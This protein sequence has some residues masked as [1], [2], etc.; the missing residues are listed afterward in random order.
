[1][2][3]SRFRIFKALIE[4]YTSKK[5]H[6]LL[7]LQKFFCDLKILSWAFLVILCSVYSAQSECKVVEPADWK[8]IYS[9]T[10]PRSD[11]RPPETT[12]ESI[13]D[14]HFHSK[15]VLQMGS[16]NYESLPSFVGGAFVSTL[17]P[18]FPYE[19][20]DPFITPPWYGLNAYSSISLDLLVPNASVSF[21][22]SFSSTKDVE[23]VSYINSI[24][25]IPVQSMPFTFTLQ[26]TDATGRINFY[27]HIPQ[28]SGPNVTASISNIVFT[29]S[30]FV[31][32]NNLVVTQSVNNFKFDGGPADYDLVLGRNTAVSFEAS[33]SD[34]SIQLVTFSAKLSDGSKAITQ[35]ATI[36]SAAQKITMVFDPLIPG[37][38]DL[39]L[40]ATGGGVQDLNVPMKAVRVKSTNPLDITYASMTCALCKQTIS[41]NDF[42]THIIQSNLLIQAMYPISENSIPYQAWANLP[43]APENSKAL[44][45]PKIKTSSIA[46]LDLAKLET[47]SH[48][49]SSFIGVVPEDYF[50]QNGFV[51]LGTVKGLANHIPDKKAPFKP[52]GA[53]VNVNWWV[54]TAHEIAHT[55]GLRHSDATP[56]NI[57]GYWVNKLLKIEL[58]DLM[59]ST[60]L[61]YRR[62][63]VSAW[64][65]DSEYQLIFQKLLT[66]PADPQTLLV[67]GFLDR[68]GQ[69]G[70]EPL[71]FIPNGVASE[72][73]STDTDIVKSIGPDGAVLAQASFTP[74]F[75]LYGDNGIEYPRDISFFIVELPVSQLSN[76][77]EIYQNGK[78]LAA[79]NPTGQLLI[80][81][82]KQIANSSYNQNSE[83]EKRELLNEANRIERELKFCQTYGLNDDE[84]F[85]NCSINIERQLL[86][87]RERLDKKLNDSIPSDLSQLSK[88]ET[89]RDVDEV[90]L[91]VIPNLTIEARRNS[92]HIHVLPS[93]EDCK[94]ERLFKLSSITQGSFGSVSIDNDGSITY[95]PSSNQKKSDR[96]VVSIQSIDGDTVTKNISIVAPKDNGH[97]HR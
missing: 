94:G 20:P 69:I 32:T 38:F 42:Q 25:L 73:N 1:M 58:P 68:D 61:L 71:A 12:Y 4:T 7:F 40:T 41:P 35:K 59:G 33:S 90:I 26:T 45:N 9:A 83:N 89:L 44:P 6:E 55:F 47:L 67:S 96:F 15:K 77:I 92:M 62:N 86:G 16:F 8:M 81:T 14:F 34:G 37:T 18:D 39:Q 11:A 13:Y 54:T 56:D 49:G 50:D 5:L 23:C 36:N 24:T 64:I 57:R 95:S 48:K 84:K 21:T 76:S 2:M 70:L 29:D 53:L 80:D 31:V 88:T 28:T 93:Y 51:P 74:S 60:D 75:T 46:D 27:C 19:L 10:T 82:I 17:N 22:L 3:L 72:F 43:G 78:K 97:D 87:L 66:N 65:S 79:I 63:P 85:S 91:Q 30:T 52:Q